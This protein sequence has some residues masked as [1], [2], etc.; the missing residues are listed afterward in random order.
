MIYIMDN[1][2]C[3]VFILV[4]YVNYIIFYL[5]FMFLYIYLY[6]M[7]YKI[8]RF[9]LIYRYIYRIQVYGLI[10]FELFYMV[11]IMGYA[12]IF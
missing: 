3:Y 8:C 1:I 6:D 12:C 2:V 5:V 10:C 7:F 9:K 4:N 11:F